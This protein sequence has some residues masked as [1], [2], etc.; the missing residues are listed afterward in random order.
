M[1]S[2]VNIMANV[3]KKEL[4]KAKTF[5]GRV[6]AGG[7]AMVAGISIWNIAMTALFI[8]GWVFY[9]KIDKRPGVPKGLRTGALIMG[10]LGTLFTPLLGPLFIGTIVLSIKG[11]KATGG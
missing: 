7:A 10:I 2:N 5:L 11:L 9:A 6:M 8:T 4:K 1:S 3:D